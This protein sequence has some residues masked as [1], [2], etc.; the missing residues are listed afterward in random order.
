M[1]TP[2]NKI[3]RCW[4]LTLLFAM[5]VF[6]PFLSLLTEW[7]RFPFPRFCYIKRACSNL[8]EMFLFGNGV[9]RTASG[10]LE[11]GSTPFLSNPLVFVVFIIF[12]LFHYVAGDRHVDLYLSRK[13][14]RLITGRSLVRTQEGP[15]TSADV[16]MHTSYQTPTVCTVTTT[17]CDKPSVWFGKATLAGGLWFR[18]G[19][20]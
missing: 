1:I 16:Y 7:V 14:N 4:W 11:N 2:K 5:C 10:W 17:K 3:A 12:H 13:R 6:S 8:L 9:R 19:K 20:C 18:D 15:L